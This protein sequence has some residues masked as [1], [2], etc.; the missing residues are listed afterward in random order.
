MK[1]K[2]R[3]L[4]VVLRK[5]YL[6]CWD[7]ASEV[8]VDEIWC[9]CDGMCWCD[10]ILLM[11]AFLRCCCDVM[12][13]GKW[14]DVRCDRCDVVCI[15]TFVEYIAKCAVMGCDAESTLN[16]NL[17]TWNAKPQ[18]GNHGARC[19]LMRYNVMCC[20]MWCDVIWCDVMWC[21]WW[22]DVWCDVEHMW[23][24]SRR[25]MWCDVMHVD[26]L[27][28]R[29]TMRASHS[30]RFKIGCWNGPGNTPHALRNGRKTS[31]KGAKIGTR[32]RSK[33]TC[34]FRP[35]TE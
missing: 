12:W 6:G 22:C 2:T 21:G 15:E 11:W 4:V 29:K 13:C 14:C 32:K 30:C 9:R 31:L 24:T 26:V 3:K 5:T 16:P 8:F 33:L 10:F 34:E 19:D 1:S 17:Q 35:E 25:V 27:R 18:T 28:V 23:C 7:V 20:A